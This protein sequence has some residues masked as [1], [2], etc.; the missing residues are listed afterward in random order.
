MTL[1]RKERLIKRLAGEGLKTLGFFRALEPDDWA[2]QVY[3]SGSGW[4]VRAVCYHLLNAEQGFHLLISDILHGGSGSPEGMNI[5]DYNEQQIREMARME[6]T[7]LLEAFAHAR[8]KT[9]AL[10]RGMQ[11]GDLDRQGRH[12]FFGIAPLEKMLK[13][14]YRHNMI[15]QRDI[16]RALDK[17]S[18]VDDLSG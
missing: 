1:T 14:I 12:P 13:L 4:T 5:D 16:R 9:I 2:V 18:P 6:T 3:T 8:M 15:H 11:P 7:A 17:G 10:V